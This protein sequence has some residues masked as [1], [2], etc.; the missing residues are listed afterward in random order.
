MYQPSHVALA[1]RLVSIPGGTGGIMA[2]LRVM[3]DL[4]GK[5][6]V[7]PAIISAA[8]SIVFLT[9]QKDSPAELRALFDWV[10]E[11]VRYVRDVLD[12]ETVS[13]AQRTLQTR[14]GDCDDQVVLLASLCEA[15]GY[16]TRFVV[17][18]YTVANTFE[19]VYLEVFDGSEW[20]PC[21]PT[22]PQSFGWEPPGA[23]TLF[24]EG[25]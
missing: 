6:R 24:I 2:T 18:A 9:L 25:V 17:G 13:T 20:I 4:V 10:R 1:G 23:L 21:D 11:N 7:D 8:R 3:R 15:I 12:V 14:S 19:H 5:G 16:Q 22:E